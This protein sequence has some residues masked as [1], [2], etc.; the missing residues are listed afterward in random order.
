MMALCLQL[1]ALWAQRWTKRK[2]INSKVGFFG[3]VCG[4]RK[5]KGEQTMLDAKCAHVRNEVQY[6]MMKCPFDKEQIQ[7]G[8]VFKH[9]KKF[10][11]FASIFLLLNKGI[12]SLIDS[13][14]FKVV[15]EIEK[16]LMKH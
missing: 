10:I 2:A 12:Q 9:K 5:N 8:V 11:Q 16:N 13:K 15:F 7:F 6:A 3:K 1:D 4:K 14:S